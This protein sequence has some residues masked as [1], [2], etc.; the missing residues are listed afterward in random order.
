[1]IFGLAA[2]TRLTFLLTEFL[3]LFVFVSR[4]AKFLDEKSKHLSEAKA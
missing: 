2:Q 1:L 3:F 4:Y